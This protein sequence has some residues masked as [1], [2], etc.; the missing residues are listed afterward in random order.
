MRTLPIE[1]V[2]TAYGLTWVLLC[3]EVSI[4]KKTEPWRAVEFAIGARGEADPPRLTGAARDGA[5]R[6][7]L[8][9]DY[10]HVRSADR[11]SVQDAV[12]AFRDAPPFV[13]AFNAAWD[14]TA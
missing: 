3:A 4:G 5:T 11:G 14:G 8:R 12:R 13:A 7:R 9:V 10:Q 6:V 1:Y 2:S